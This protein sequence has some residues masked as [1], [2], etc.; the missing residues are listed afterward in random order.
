MAVHRCPPLLC[1]LLHP[2]KE[3]GCLVLRTQPEVRLQ[4]RLPVGVGEGHLEVV[5]VVQEAL[6][7][8]C[9]ECCIW[10]ETLSEALLSH[11]VMSR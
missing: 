8:S 9:V 6:F 11:S 4:Q 1:L 2:P 5:E 3:E 10:K 7:P